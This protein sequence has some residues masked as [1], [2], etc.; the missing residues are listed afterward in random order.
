[1][2]E[3]ESRGDKEEMFGDKRKPNTVYVIWPRRSC[4]G[5]G[6]APKVAISGNGCIPAAD[7]NQIARSTDWH[8]NSDKSDWDTPHYLHL[9]VSY[10]LRIVLTR[11]GNYA[12][13]VII[14]LLSARVSGTIIA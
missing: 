4:H 11:E 14:S 10:W 2:G 8:D 3:I 9:P 1:M 12:G 7:N 13:P 6:P 5:P